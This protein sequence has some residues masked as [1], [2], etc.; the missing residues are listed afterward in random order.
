MTLRVTFLGTSGAVPTP[1]RNTSAVMIN[2]DGDRL[3]FDCGEGT[4]RQ[5]M[6]AGTGFAI[7]SCF[8]TH[9]HGDHVYGLPGLLDTL[10]FND[11][12]RPLT[13]Y[14]PTGTGDQ[15]R[16]WL[17][18]I[19]GTPAFRLTVTEVTPGETALDAADYSIEAF[20]VDHDTTAVGYALV[21]EE[22]KG[23]FDRERAEALGVPVGPKFSQLHE[24]TPVELEDGR[25]IE[26]ADVVG[27]PRPGRRVVYTGDTR[28][29]PATTAVAEEA[30]LLIHDGTFR[31][32]HAERAARTGHTTAKEAGEVAAEAAVKR[33][34]LSHLSSR[35]GEEY[36]PHRQQAAAAFDGPVIVPEDGDTI[37]VPYPE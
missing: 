2:R 33:L 29:A 6:Q 35:Y 16:R 28:P 21:E 19:G 37:E 22:R 25:V 34:G 4:Q 20:A 7:D 13:V 36:T 30:D 9:L 5:M 26:P 10:S 1:Q 18:E 24:G 11:R 32:T 8:L 17:G 14:V 3:L 15:L 23:R 31:D 12:T 27:P